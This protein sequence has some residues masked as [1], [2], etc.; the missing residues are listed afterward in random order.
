MKTQI[1][2]YNNILNLYKLMPSFEQP[3]QIDNEESAITE[4]GDFD[5]IE[6]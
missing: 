6:N 1:R 3:K 2:S 4:A 5:M